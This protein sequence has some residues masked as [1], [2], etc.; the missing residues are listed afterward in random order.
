MK[1]RGVPHPHLAFCEIRVGI[2]P[3]T[4]SEMPIYIVGRCNFRNLRGAFLP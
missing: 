1:S 4:Y 2:F 3:T